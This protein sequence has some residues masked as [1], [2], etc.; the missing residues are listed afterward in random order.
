[1]AH[2]LLVMQLYRYYGN[3]RLV[4]EQYEAAKKWLLLVASQNNDGIIKNGLSDHEGLVPAPA[5]PMV[6]PL[7]YQS[8]RLL[9]DMARLLNRA[10]DV[11][12]FEALAEKSRAAYQE[13]FVDPATGKAGPGTQASQSF[14]LYSGLVPE[15][16]RP[17]ALDV[18]IDNIRGER[19]G[20]LSTG[21]MGTK[22]M[23]DVL[24]REGHADVAYGIVSQRDFPGWG[25][26]LENGA[27]TLWEHWAFSD[28]TFSH[29]HQMFGSISQWFI[30]W[31]GGIQPAPDAAGCDRVVIRP[32]FVDGIDSVRCS[33]KSVRGT[34][35]SSWRR[36]GGRVKL[37]LDIPVN[38]VA[39]LSLVSGAEGDVVESGKP[40]SKA[41]GVV[42]LQ[43]KPGSVACGLGSGHYVFEFNKH[44]GK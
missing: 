24:S 39:E 44:T 11:K 3:E 5:P 21:I 19:K 43:S 4:A 13:K 41:D 25:W 7:F 31:L 28:N 20:H 34:I 9:A 18:L 29:S 42:L 16:L 38:V 12:Q 17:K 15:Q 1:M 35:A 6:T 14:A 37:V 32:R 23:L 22:F 2:P 27:T 26:M 10:D 40:L 33:Y 36:D 30:N 8:A